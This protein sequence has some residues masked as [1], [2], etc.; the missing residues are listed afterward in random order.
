MC[1]LQKDGASSIGDSEIGAL[2]PVLQGWQ[3]KNLG[4]EWS[5]KQLS[6]TPPPKKTTLTRHC[7]WG[8]T[9]L[10]LRFFWF[11]VVFRR[12]W[13]MKIWNLF[14][15]MQYT[16]YHRPLCV[17][18]LI[19]GGF[20]PSEKNTYFIAL[21]GKFQWTPPG[22]QTKKKTGGHWVQD[23]TTFQKPSPLLH[24]QRLIRWIL[25]TEMPQ[26]AIHPPCHWHACGRSTILWWSPAG[27]MESLSLGAFI[28]VILE[29]QMERFV[30]TFVTFFLHDSLFMG[31]VLD[32]MD[33][34]YNIL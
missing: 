13:W 11:D 30:E 27:E 32:W 25:F 31:I 17:I 22:P 6:N 1:P 8:R 21:Y 2:H 26:S 19:S 4:V 23:V 7:G 20:K 15:F 10:K 24:T 33:F 18:W 29:Q 14:W 3:K 5:L 12:F 34:I 9:S 16:M 28:D